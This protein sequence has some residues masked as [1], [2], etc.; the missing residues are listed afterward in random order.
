[1]SSRSLSDWLHYIAAIHPR[2]IEL[3]LDRIRKVA[4]KLGIHKPAPCVITVA[5][6]NGK[7]SCVQ[8]LKV[9]LRSQGLRTGAYTSPHIESFN[10]RIRCNGEEATDIQL[11]AAFNKIEAARGSISLSYFEYTTLAALVIFQQS[12]LDV[13]LLEVGLGGRLDATNIIDADVAIITNIALD[14]QDWLGTDREQIG[15]EK[16]GILRRN[17]FVVIG[18]QDIPVSILDLAAELQCKVFRPGREYEFDTAADGTWS[19]R[20]RDAA[21]ESLVFDNLPVPQLEL[22]NVAAA[23]QALCLTNHAL[24]DTDTLKKVMRTLDLAGRWEWRLDC[25]QQIPVLL[26]VAHNPAGAELAGR[27]LAL[28]RKNATSRAR[29]IAV[30]AVMADKDIE[31]MA[32]A[33]ESLLDICYIAQ[34]DDARCMPAA[35]ARQRLAASSPGLHV[36]EFESV[37]S[38]YQQALNSFA[39]GDLIVVIGSFM[40]VAAVRPL[41]EPLP[42]S[43]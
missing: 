14:H 7:G 9:V 37:R 25:A 30:M 4:S 6:T 12:N 39:A 11:V 31:A 22:M 41:T 1:M 10:E 26:D 18:S 32:H 23:L 16:A 5:G 28:W 21:G 17:Q 13:V 27:K 19:W 43:F 34:F 38:A 42:Q 40:T 8:T 2:E 15:K 35:T 24:P 29:I 20:G 36:V 33:L 3:G